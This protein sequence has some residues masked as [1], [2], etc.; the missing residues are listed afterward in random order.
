MIQTS[1]FQQPEKEIIIDPSG[2]QPK[3]LEEVITDLDIVPD[4]Y[5]IYP[6]GGFH[7]FYGV[8]NALPRYKEQIWPYIKRIKFN[9]RYHSMESV[10]NVRKGHMRNDI[11][12]TISQVGSTLNQMG[13]VVAGIDT[14]KT[15][16]RVSTGRQDIKRTPVS[17]HRAVGLAFIPNPNNK[18]V[19]MH[20]N[21]DS[22]NYL[23]ENLK[24]GTSSENNMGK[25]MR[26]PDTMEQKYANLIH[27]DVLKG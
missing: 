27:K 26:R 5:M 23:R 25:L 22:T 24:W 16:I 14:T 12:L 8:A 6:G 13:R 4:T 1:F 9:E 7:P 11:I 19:V 15:F 20:I 2:L 21:D 18:L 10:N 17:L 3:K